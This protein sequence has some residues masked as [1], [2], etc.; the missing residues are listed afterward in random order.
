M[1]GQRCNGRGLRGTKPCVLVV[2]TLPN[3]WLQWA[4]SSVHRPNNNHSSFVRPHV[5]TRGT[6]S[7]L[8]SVR[9][10]VYCHL[11]STPTV[12]LFSYVPYVLLICR[13]VFIVSCVP[14]F[15]PCAW[16]PYVFLGSLFSAGVPNFYNISAYHLHILKFF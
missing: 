15:N 5:C 1:S 6:R 12:I 3:I 11:R 16:V 13:L 14:L 8:V 10:L 7:K 9:L 4:L 2:V